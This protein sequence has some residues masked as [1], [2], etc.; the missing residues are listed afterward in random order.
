MLAGMQAEGFEGGRLGC[1]HDEL[2]KGGRKAGF[3]AAFAT[4]S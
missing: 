3:A 2:G 4:L 1:G